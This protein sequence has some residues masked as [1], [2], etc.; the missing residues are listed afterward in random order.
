MLGQLKFSSR[1]EQLNFVHCDVASHR[2]GAGEA[3]FERIRPRATRAPDLI[4]AVLTTVPVTG[5]GAKHH[6]GEWLAQAQR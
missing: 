2:G 1:A 4:D 6:G 3:C 5:S